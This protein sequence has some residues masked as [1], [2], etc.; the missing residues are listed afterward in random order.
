MSTGTGLASRI[1]RFLRNSS[2]VSED[3]VL[4]LSKRDRSIQRTV[5]LLKAMEE[6]SS[7][8]EDSS[9]PTLKK[10]RWRLPSASSFGKAEEIRTS[11][12]PEARPAAY[13]N[14]LPD[15][16][17]NEAPKLGGQE[18]ASGI[19]K[20]TS[21]LPPGSNEQEDGV[22]GPSTPSVEDSETGWWVPDDSMGMPGYHYYEE[23]PD[24]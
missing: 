8:G 4:R 20:P 13:S 12:I 21:P 24:G 5:D 2:W 1:W 22:T 3:G 18:Q 9:P 10:E 11:K 7:S 16:G 14:T 19:P 6:E 15:T 17:R 23:D